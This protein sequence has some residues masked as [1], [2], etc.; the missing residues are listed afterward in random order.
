MDLQAAARMIAS[1]PPEG[2]AQALN[3]LSQGF[4]AHTGLTW[5]WAEETRVVGTLE[6]QVHHTQPYGL[7]HGGV[8]ATLAEAACSV[9]AALTLLPEGRNGVGV[10]NHTRFHRASRPGTTLTVT[11]RPVATTGR[12]HTWEAEITEAD[13]VCCATATVVVRA[14]D[15]DA[16]VAGA[17]VQL[18]PDKPA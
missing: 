10:E 5:S 8:Y 18:L 4:D 14:L 15:P 9:G 6:V 16:R 1:L 12:N 3:A 7:V 13:G 2:R 11:A 17:V